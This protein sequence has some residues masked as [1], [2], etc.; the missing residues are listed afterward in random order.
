[1]TRPSTLPRWAT[2]DPSYVIEPEESKKDTGW[3]SQEKP[4]YQYM[5]WLFE[6]IYD[7][8][9][10]FDEEADI[11]NNHRLMVYYGTPQGV[12]G[13]WDDDLAAQVFSRYDFIVFGEGLQDSAHT[14]HTST[15][16]IVSKIHELNPNAKIFGY[17][18]L[19]VSTNNFTQVEMEGFTDDWVNLIG[20]DGIFLDDAGY[21]FLVSRTRQNDIIDY[22]HDTYEFPVFINAWVPDDVM[23]SAVDATYNPG[24]DATSLGE[25]DYYLLESHLVNDQAYSAQNGYATPFDLKTKSDTCITYRQTLGVKM[26][27]INQLEFTSFADAEIDKFF[28]M[29]EMAAMIFGLDGYGMVAYQYSA[30]APNQNVVR[31]FDFD[32]RYD[33]YFNEDG[34]YYV[35]GGWNTFSRFDY[36]VTL[37]LNDPDYSYERP[38]EDFDSLITFDTLNGTVEIANDLEVGGT[39]TTP[40]ITDFTN[41]THDHL[42]TA[43]GGALAQIPPIGSIIPFYDFN[44]ALSFDGGHWAYCDGSVVTVSGIGSQTLPDL[45]GRYLVG[46]GSDGAGDLDSASWSTSAVGNAAHQINLSHSHT[47]NSH[48]HTVNSHTH[49]L[50]NHTHSVSAHT[51]S[52][53]DH[54]HTIGYVYGSNFGPNGFNSNSGVHS[55][56]TFTTRSYMF[57]GMTFYSSTSTGQTPSYRFL[58]SGPTDGS[59]NSVSM[60][61]N[62]GGGGNTGTPSNNNSGSSS[63]GTSSSSPGTDSQLS[64]TQSIQ[65]RSIQV[66][67]IM[68]IA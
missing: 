12:N 17:I 38:Q 65:P 33:R 44:G 51:H 40:T 45:S 61:A 42:D 49:D 10:Y 58:S 56:T 5:N 63:P 23:S 19:G 26:M 11:T 31:T 18:D 28:R 32:P 20:A 57:T 53:N 64:S 13:L 37:Y 66:R 35:D 7:W 22:I 27:A 34:T 30:L 8:L 36:D 54:Y 3:L 67:F 55:Y 2:G 50:S 14:Y 6:T 47:V 59:H 39:I 21:D 29:A 43:G 16:N 4:P 1:M 15:I 62:S 41:A 25:D 48:S 9:T 52:I 24:G 46:F 68:R 60:T